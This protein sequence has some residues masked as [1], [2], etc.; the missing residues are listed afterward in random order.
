LWW[1]NLAQQFGQLDGRRRGGLEEGVVEGQLAHLPRGRFDQRA[2]AVADVDAPQARHR[3]EDL[4]ALAVPQPDAVAARDDARALLRERLEV[5][6]RMEEVR[7][8]GALPVG[9]GPVHTCSSRCSRS[10]GEIT[11]MNSAYSTSLIS[12]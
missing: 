3:V 12:V 11:F 4:L 2:L 6:E 8:V 5:G 10:H 7:R 1:R 9:G